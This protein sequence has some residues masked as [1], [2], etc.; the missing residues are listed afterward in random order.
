MSCIHPRIERATRT[1]DEV[2]GAF[3]AAGAA[4]AP[5]YKPSELLEDPQVKA[6]ELI[7]SVKDQDLG[8][9]R[10]QNVMWRM[11]RT[12]GR[13]RSTG[14]QL[15]ADT[16]EILAT[17]GL[18]ESEINELHARHRVLTRRGSSTARST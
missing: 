2:I 5:V 15:G 11:G 9:M 7:T 6:L 13:I 4:V 18:T 10:M 1:R 14:R 3:E 8:T 17:E 12:P 16:A